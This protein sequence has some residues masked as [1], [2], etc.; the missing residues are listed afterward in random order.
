VY[1][2]VLTFWFEELGPKEWWSSGPEVDAR[3]RQRYLGLL[4]RA[5]QGELYAWR[6][7]P[8]GRLAEIIVLDQFSR[9]IYRDRAESY[10]QDAMALVL[11]QEAVAA[12]AHEPLSLTERAFLLIPYMHSESKVVHLQ[13]EILYREFAPQDNYEFEVRHKVI[14]DRFGR[15]PHRNEIMGRTSTPEELE[16]LRQPGSR[17]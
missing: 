14:I 3:I 1:E 8:H 2:G 4:Q 6:S 11:A 13:G 12:Q 5:A 15:Y 10:S 7:R 16:F 9:N 17:F